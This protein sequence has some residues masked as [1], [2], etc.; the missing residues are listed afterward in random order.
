MHSS[1]NTDEIGVV[2]IL[3]L[4]DRAIGKT[5]LMLR[6]TTNEFSSNYMTTLG[7]EFKSKVVH[8][9]GENILVQIW[10]TA[11]QEKFR[12]LQES[13]TERHPG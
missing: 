10:D 5:S 13:I 8:I 1:R 2:K 4:G 9:N 11:G 12:K 6:N 7:I 3:I